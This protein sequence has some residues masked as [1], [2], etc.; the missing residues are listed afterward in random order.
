[1]AMVYGML[2]NDL[3]EWNHANIPDS[4]LDPTEGRETETHVTVLYELIGN[5]FWGA[6]LYLTLRG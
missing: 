3:R 6:R 1:M 2:E 4:A 5:C